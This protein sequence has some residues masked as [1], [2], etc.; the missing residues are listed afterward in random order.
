MSV[1]KSCNKKQSRCECDYFWG[2]DLKRLR[3]EYWV[4]EF[5]DSVAGAAKHGAPEHILVSMKSFAKEI[6]EGYKG[7]RWME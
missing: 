4:R 6:K 7:H 3:E 2:G 5:A 1:C